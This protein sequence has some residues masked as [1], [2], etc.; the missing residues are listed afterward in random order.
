MGWVFYR[1]HPLFGREVQI[2]R[3]YPQIPPDGILIVLPDSSHCVLPGWMLDEAACNCLADQ[4]QPRIDLA[5]LA[6]VRQLLDSQ[7]LSIRDASDNPAVVSPPER[8]EHAQTP[9]TPATPVHRG[10]RRLADSASENTGALPDAD[11][12]TSSPNR[13]NTRKRK[14]QR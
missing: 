10:R 12:P 7:S 14:E 4:D 9:E 11:R 5:A 2:V 6:A 1:Y 8:P 3:R 13:T